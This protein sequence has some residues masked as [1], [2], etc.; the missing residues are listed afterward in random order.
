MVGYS[1]WGCK[2]SDTTEQFHFHFHYV[3]ATLY[4]YFFVSYSEPRCM[5]AHGIPISQ[6]RSYVSKGGCLE[7]VAKLGSVFMFGVSLCDEAHEASQG[8]S[9]QGCLRKEHKCLFPGH[10][11]SHCS[12]QSPGSPLEDLL[13]G[14]S[15]EHR[16]RT[17]RQTWGGW[18]EQE[19]SA[20][21][22][23]SLTEEAGL[24]TLIP[25]RQCSLKFI[26]APSLHGTCSFSHLPPPTTHPVAQAQHQEVIP[27][28]SLPLTCPPHPFPSPT[29][30]ITS[31]RSPLHPSED[32]SF[33]L[34][35][36]APTVA[37]PRFSPRHRVNSSKYGT[38]NVPFLAELY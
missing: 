6:M 31:V 33:L 7:S 35:L 37:P 27:D 16:A 18:S 34:S 12:P 38:Y 11:S 9:S 1:P 14:S 22:E 29:S 17:T 30:T 28:S 2:E 10:L 20:Q 21:T 3:L 36:S 26:S 15:V 24:E 13:E 25:R 5:V 32:L 19:E 23:G 8:D 4:I